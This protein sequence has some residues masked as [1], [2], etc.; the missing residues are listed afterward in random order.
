MYSLHKLMWYITSGLLNHFL[1]QRERERDRETEREREKDGGREGGRE[2]DTCKVC[3]T[4]KVRVVA[5]QD[6]EV[7]CRLHSG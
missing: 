2:G 1:T 4:M 3:D 6:S 7:S 5:E